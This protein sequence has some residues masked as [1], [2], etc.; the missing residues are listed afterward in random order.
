MLETYFVKPQTVDRIR[1]CWIGAEIERYVGWLA[2]QGYSRPDSAAPGA[3]AGRLRGVRPPARRLGSG[4]PAGSCR[5]FR[6]QAGG[7]PATPPRPGCRY[8]QGIR[9]PVEQMLDGGPARLRA[10][11]PAHTVSCPF[12]ARCRGSSSTWST[13]VACARPRSWRYRHHLDR[14]EAYLDRIGV[15]G[16]AELSPALLS[17]FV[18]ERA[19]AG[20]AKT[21]VR[22]RLRGAAR[23]PALRAPP[24]LAGRRPEQAVEWPQ[25]YRLSSIPRSIS[26]ADVGQVLAASTAAPRA[27]SATTRS[28]CCW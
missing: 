21:T 16:L 23:V 3:G 4:G 26:W 20:L 7:D 24:G 13:S 22:E 19:G 11:R 12:A 8:C 18:A 5:C 28:C 9:G 10:H 6:R 1:A 2:E 25:A 27:G 17:A 15:A 14:F